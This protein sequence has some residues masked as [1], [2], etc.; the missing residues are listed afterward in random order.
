MLSDRCLSVTLLH[1]GQTVGRINMKLGIQVGLGPGNIVS[2]GEPAPLPQRGT[3]SKFSAHICC[4]QMAGW[5]K[6]PLGIE[7]GLGPGDC[8]RWGRSSPLQKGC[9]APIFGPYL[10]C[11]NR[12]MDQ[13]GTWHG[14]GPRSRPHCARCGRSFPPQKGQSSHFSAHFCCG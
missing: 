6:T 1:C 4:G 13:D 3:V 5:I 8:V 14:G 11:P 7:V 10:L 12:W 2:D 9:R